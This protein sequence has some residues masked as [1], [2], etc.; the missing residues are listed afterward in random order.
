MASPIYYPSGLL[1]ATENGGLTHNVKHVLEHAVIDEGDVQSERE[2]MG[3]PPN[4]DAALIPITTN[5]FHAGYSSLFQSFT[6]EKPGFSRTKKLEKRHAHFLLW[7]LLYFPS[8]FKWR[9]ERWW[10]AAAH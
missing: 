6:R 8:F 10:H 2:K 5:K 7:L 1:L 9:G 3:E 4:I